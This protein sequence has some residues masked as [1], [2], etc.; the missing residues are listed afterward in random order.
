MISHILMWIIVSL[1]TGDIKNPPDYG[2]AKKISE[3]P[4]KICD[5]RTCRNLITTW[6]GSIQHRERLGGNNIKFSTRSKYRTPSSLV[7]YLLSPYTLPNKSLAGWE[8]VNSRGQPPP[9]AA[10]PQGDKVVIP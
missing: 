9:P 1:L 10:Q 4:H 8:H 3:L 5:H 6:Y 2:V 7:E